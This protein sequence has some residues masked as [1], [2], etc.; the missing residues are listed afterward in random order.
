MHPY[1][2]SNTLISYSILPS[3]TTHPSENLYSRY[4]HLFSVPFSCPLSNIPIQ[5]TRFLIMRHATCILAAN[6]INY[7]M[8]STVRVFWIPPPNHP[9]RKRP[10]KFYIEHLYLL[11]HLKLIFGSAR[12]LEPENLPVNRPQSE[13]ARFFPSNRLFGI[14]NI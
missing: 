2:N 1:S 6:Y 9:L 11:L 13:K 10:N 8:I 5:T 7:D 14:I 12:G 4:T 3:H